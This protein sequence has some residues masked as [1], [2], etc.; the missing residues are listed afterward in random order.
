MLLQDLVKKYEL[1]D[2][3][4]AFMQQY[5]FEEAEKNFR[6][7]LEELAPELL[8]YRWQALQLPWVG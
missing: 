4:A 8:A 3:T 1:S 7:P 5:G 2:E 6:W